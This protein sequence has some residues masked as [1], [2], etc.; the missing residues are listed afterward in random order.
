MKF[1]LHQP[2]LNNQVSRTFLHSAL[3]TAALLFLAI[4]SAQLLAPSSSSAQQNSQ[5]RSERQNNKSARKPSCPSCS[6]RTAQF[7]YEPLIGLPE[8]EGSELVFNSRSPQEVDVVPTFYKLDGTAIVGNSVRLKPVEIRYVDLKKLIPGQ[9]RNDQDWGGMSLAFTGGTRE[10]WAQLRMTG[11]NGGGSVDEFFTV[12][13]EARSE[14]Q[15]AIWWAPPQSLAIIALGNITDARTSAIVSFGDGQSKTVNLPPHA[16]EIIRYT[17]NFRAGG[18]AVTIQTTGTA[19]SVIPTG[20]VA[21]KNGSFN[22]VIRFYDT[23]AARQQH[24]FANGL[25]LAGVT[26]HMLLK[27]TSSAPITATPEFSPA[28][29]GA[30][31]TP[32]TLPAITLR[33]QQIVEVDLDPLMKAAQG[34]NDLEA[35]SVKVINGGAPGSLIGAVY[36][37][38]NTTGVN[39]DVPL[40]DS[41]P[42]RNA[43]GSYP[44][45]VDDDYSTLVSITNI[46]SQPAAFIATIRYEGGEYLPPMRTLA[47]GET[48]V[49]DLNKIRD[50][51]IPD[52][53]GKTLPRKATLGQF[54]WSVLRG[55]DDVR[56]IGR[57]EMV[58]VSKKASSSYSCPVCCPDS[59]GELMLSPNTLFLPTGGSTATYVDGIWLDCYNN[60]VGPFG[61]PYGVDW[62]CE[63]T[64][65]ISIAHQSGNQY[66]VGG[67]TAGTSEMEADTMEVYYNND[68]MDCYPVWFPYYAPGDVNV[69]TVTLTATGTQEVNKSDHYISLINTGNVTITATLNPPGTNPSIIA[70][71]GGSTGSDN[72]H[73]VVSTSSASN[74]V[75]TATVG[76]AEA[77]SVVIHVVDATTPP[78]AAINAPKTFSLGGTAT[79]PSSSF[80]LTV[81]T[82][83]DQGIT[84]PTFN[85]D[86][87][88]SSDRW[89]FRLRDVSHS[90]KLGVQPITFRIDLPNGNPP[91]FPLAPGMNLVQSHA[92]ARSDLDTTGLTTTGPNRDYYWVQFITQNHEQAH[93]DHFYSTA[94]W[95]NYMGLFES[96]D[97]EA[98]SVFVVF[99]CNDTTTTTG[100]AAV[101]K[102][103]P[104]WNT[105][106]TN[107]HNAA[108][109][110]EFMTSEAYAHG[111]SNPQYGPIRNAI[112]NP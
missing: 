45:R 77:D 4:G 103:T 15:E 81:V 13:Q 34:R 56:L 58:S 2:I 89:V 26:P 31:G 32:I 104:T 38:N 99:D 19:G 88:F 92:Q 82:I 16:T 98:T 27:N 35:V 74:T 67:L 101:S 87:H 25:R 96:D 24:L 70:W 112:P 68:G 57:G 85:V 10:L 105:A 17:P 20:L 55:S 95:L 12:S 72:L 37:A 11:I 107:Q 1:K 49:F 48:A 21:S 3:I 28:G 51:Q 106:V 78:A 80:G 52:K 73:R 64:S 46:G 23:R 40:R 47:V 83:G 71:S 76:E 54:H 102:L 6:E 53:D 65:V 18:A 9:Y 41:G 66:N 91:I 108:D 86:P 62:W 22:S 8:A 36:S 93:V 111:V 44:W 75:V 97:V 30:A 110:A 50:E 109:T 90:Y 60:I 63:N 5:K 14:A 69:V 42:L 59:F 100:V 61:Y 29:N 33:P 84:R 79:V 94:F 43:A 39:Y 7:I